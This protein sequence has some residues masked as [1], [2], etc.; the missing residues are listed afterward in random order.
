MFPGGTAS[1]LTLS[2]RVGKFTPASKLF[3]SD[4]TI[5]EVISQ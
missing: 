2:H 3:I 4:K 1:F 5:F